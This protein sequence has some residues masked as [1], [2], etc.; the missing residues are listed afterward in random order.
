M[1]KLFRIFLVCVIPVIGFAQEADIAPLWFGLTPLIRDGLDENIELI[2]AGVKVLSD[3][4]RFMLYQ[5]HKKTPWEGFA[6]NMLV[7]FGAGSFY[8]GESGHGTIL[9]AADLMAIA[10]VTSGYF[11]SH[12]NMFIPGGVLLFSISRI[13]GAILPF[14]HA[15]N[16]N[17]KLLDIL[18]GRIV[19]P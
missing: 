19:L 2:S 7:G 15:N 18:S 6:L 16:Y 14:I 9:L 8:Q 4:Q 17:R 5:I 3:E 12:Q 11:I 13:A 10:M 1:K